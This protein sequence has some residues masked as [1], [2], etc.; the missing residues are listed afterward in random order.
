MNKYR[1]TISHIENEGNCAKLERDGFTREKIMKTMYKETD[2]ASTQER[3]A[4]IKNLYKR[5]PKKPV[6]S[7]WI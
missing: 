2:G 1:L 6:F 4:M 3:R 7:R 5:E